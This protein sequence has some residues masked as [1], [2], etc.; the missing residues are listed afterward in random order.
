MRN[1]QDVLGCVRARRRRIVRQSA[2]I[3]ALMSDTLVDEL[4][5][6]Q[7]QELR[8]C[9]EDLIQAVHELNAYHNIYF[10]RSPNDRADVGRTQ[11]ETEQ[12]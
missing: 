2:A 10:S 11:K 12:S 9:A 4:G 1:E 8:D 7:L 3:T 5:G 6:S